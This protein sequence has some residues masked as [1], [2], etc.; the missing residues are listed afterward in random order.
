MF[1]EAFKEDNGLRLS[2]KEYSKDTTPLEMAEALYTAEQRRILGKSNMVLVKHVAK[3]DSECVNP[4]EFDDLKI[5][6]HRYQT[7]GRASLHSSR[8]QINEDSDNRLGKW[9]NGCG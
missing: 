7:R 8:M 6:G 2:E 4:E 9:K 5:R 1:C 3:E